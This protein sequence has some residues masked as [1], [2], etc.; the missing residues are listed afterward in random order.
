MSRT[1]ASSHELAAFLSEQLQTLAADAGFRLATDGSDV[2]V[3]DG[4][5]S[6]SRNGTAAILDDTD[7]PRS[8]T[9]RTA[10]ATRAVLSHVQ[11]VISQGTGKP[12]P[13]SGSDLP[14]PGVSIEDGSLVAR[15]GDPEAPVWRSDGLQLP[16]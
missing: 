15:F 12:W 1:N 11:D 9:E 5:G 7:D 14:V 6:E 3:L 8:S 10:T 4:G 13:G 16:A 2:V